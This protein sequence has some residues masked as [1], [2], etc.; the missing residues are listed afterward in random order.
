MVKKVS[1]KVVVAKS[2]K[3][4]TDY[5]ARMNRIL[6]QVGGVKKMIESKKSG[7]EI[8][9]QLKAV[10]SAIKALEAEVLEEH[11]QSSVADLSSG[12]AAQKSKKLTDLKKIFLRFE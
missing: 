5:S 3:A 4:E 11:L 1:K 8:L 10:R 7:A 9:V 12:S 6:G 2:K